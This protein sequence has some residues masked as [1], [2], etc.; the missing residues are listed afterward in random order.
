MAMCSRAWRVSNFRIE[1]CDLIHCW[2]SKILKQWNC[3]IL[4]HERL[5]WW[6]VGI[7]GCDLEAIHV[8]VTSHVHVSDMKSYTYIYIY[9]YI[10][11]YI[12][13]CI[14][15]Y[16]YICMYM[17][18]RYIYHISYIYITGKDITGKDVWRV[19]F[20]WATSCHHYLWC[21]TLI[22]LFLLN[23]DIW[24]LHTKVRYRA[25]VYN[26]SLLCVISQSGIAFWSCHVF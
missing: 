22:C 12:Y 24:K 4:E 3:E 9:I 20:T 1:V 8:R 21:I 19:T 16:I 26:T 7:F 15:I 17:T 25:H 2:N 10:H 14:Y 13:I 6:H 11:I 5:Q 23:D 18:S